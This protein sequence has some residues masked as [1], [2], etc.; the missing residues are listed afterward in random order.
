MNIAILGGGLTGLTCAEELSGNSKA[1]ITIFEIESFCGGLAAGFTHDGWEWGLERAYHHVF[2]SDR[3]VLDYAHSIGFNDFYFKQPLTSSLYKTADGA[4]I[5][6]PLDT[7]LDLLRFPLL[8]MVQKVRAGFVLFLL[9]I[10]PFLPLFEQWTTRD[11]MRRAMGEKAFETLF[12]G[13]LQKKFGNY[14][15]NILASFLWSRIHKRTKALGYVRGGFQTF[16]DYVQNRC[17]ERGVMIQN[18]ARIVRVEKQEEGFVVTWVQRSPS[19]VWSDEQSKYFDFVVSTLPSPVAAKA[20]EKVLSEREVQKL[21]SL[22]YM[23]SMNLI[24]ETEER[25]FEREYWVSNCV[26]SVST[27]VFVQHT[28]FVDSSHYNNKHI[29]YVGNYLSTDSPLWSKSQEEL[30]AMYTSELADLTGKHIKITNSFLFRA[31]NSQPIFDASFLSNMPTFTTTHPRLFFANLDMTYPHDRGT[32]YAVKLGRSVA[33]K[34]LPTLD[35]TFTPR[36]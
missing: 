5:L 17:A 24:L 16:I 20:L 29:L 2:A 21:R 11:L 34:L 6:A 32:N 14:A 23:A 33:R 30:E 26:S 13:L 9:K 19:G 18:G 15:G 7:P 31:T 22:K 36:L 8:N 12:G 27:L 35:P 25:V 1:N 4:V 3:D 28:N 10:A